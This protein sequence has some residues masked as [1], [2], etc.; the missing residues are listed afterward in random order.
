M[1]LA[2]AVLV[3][4]P[5][6]L[7]V[8]GNR[9]T[10]GGRRVTLR[11]VCVG[12]VVLARDASRTGDYRTIRRDWNANCV[13]IGVAP[14]SWRKDRSATLRALETDVAAALKQRLFVLIDWHTIG[15]PDGYYQVP[16]WDGPITDL[17][18]SD[19][20]LATDF[21]RTMA[22][23]YGKDGRVAFHLWCEPVYTADDWKTPLGS[24]WP[25]L[26]P[27]FER[28]TKTIRAEG[29]PNLVIASGN[30][31]A[32]DLVG[33]RKRPLSDRN[34]AYEWHVYGGHDE[35][36]PKEWARKLDGLDRVAPV[37]VTEWGY[38]ANTTSHFKG[39]RETF[40]K[41]FLRFMETR[42]MSWTAWC[43]HPTWGPTMLQRDWAQPT[44]FGGFVK[45][46]LTRLNRRALRP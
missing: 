9:L 27:Y 2:A 6:L 46:S 5:A 16:T 3:F 18:D 13:R 35:N 19:F 45:E 30:R 23:T 36:D 32:Y 31:W 39:T 37:L 24:T 12:D 42:G 26:R 8:D 22:R 15:W 28:L 4:A 7:Q 10:Y 43:W 14:T 29:A 41:P 1:V 34:T 25:K 40:G 17:Y 21:W 38:D 11:G 44:E 20:T 33:I